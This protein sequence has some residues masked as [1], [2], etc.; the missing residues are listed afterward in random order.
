MVPGPKSGPLGLS[1]LP[2]CSYLWRLPSTL[3]LVLSRSC[4]QEAGSPTNGRLWIHGLPTTMLAVAPNNH[5]GLG[6]VLRKI[7]TAVPVTNRCPNSTVYF[8]QFVHPA[9]AKFKFALHMSVY[10]CVEIANIADAKTNTI[11]T[12]I[13]LLVGSVDRISAAAVSRVANVLSNANYINNTRIWF[14]VNL[15]VFCMYRTLLVIR[16]RGG[17]P[18]DLPQDHH[19]QVGL[20]PQEDPGRQPRAPGGHGH[21]RGYVHFV[22]FVP[23]SQFQYQRQYCVYYQ[24]RGGLPPSRLSPSGSPPSG[25]PSA[26]GPRPP[27]PR[28]WWSGPTCC[29]YVLCIHIVN[30]FYQLRSSLRYHQLRSSLRYSQL[31]CSLVDSDPPGQEP[32]RLPPPENPH[33]RPRAHSGHH[34]RGYVQFL[35]NFVYFGYYLHVLYRISQVSPRRCTV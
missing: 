11:G 16:H 27:T 29:T 3:L 12:S 22:Y 26:E 7:P 32:S 34:L 25:S 14:I 17:P 4:L 1:E 15:S 2:P 13:P 23:Y 35:V 5:V 20:R 9:D 10:I 30:I 24:S 6:A 21:L 8:A 33:G 28:P 31:H 18:T 19:P